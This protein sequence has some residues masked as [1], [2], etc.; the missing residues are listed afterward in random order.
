ML[1]KQSF[2]SR[3]FEGLAAAAV[4]VRVQRWWRHCLFRPPA[5]A[6]FYAI[7]PLS[8]IVPNFCCCLNRWMEPRCRKTARTESGKTGWSKLIYCTPHS[9]VSVHLMTHFTMASTLY[10]HS[11]VSELWNKKISPSPSWLIKELLKF[12]VCLLSFSTPF[13][14]LHTAAG[15]K[16]GEEVFKVKEDRVGTVLLLGALLG[17]RGS[18]V[19][20]WKRLPT[21]VL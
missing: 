17:N 2:V 12:L 4:L 13:V 1:R 5:A 14:Y 19:R 3:S 18:D 9:F 8:C 11:I 15:L 21:C 10:H 7:C 20:W 6:G 16:W